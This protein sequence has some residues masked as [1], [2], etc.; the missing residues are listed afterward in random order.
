GRS[1]LVAQFLDLRARLTTREFRLELAA[2]FPGQ[3][4][5]IDERHSMKRPQ[6]R[7]SP[8]L[9][10]V[11]QSEHR[12]PRI[13]NDRERLETELRDDRAKI[14]DVGSP[15]DG[16]A[17]VRSGFASTTLIVKE[18]IVCL[19]PLQHLRQKVPMVRAWTT[20]K[21]EQTQRIHLTIFDSV[22]RRY[23]LIGELTL[24]RHGCCV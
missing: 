14:F 2:I 12:A 13:A 11:K 20:V 8:L 17:G 3:G 21:Q 6:L 15:G 7:V 22:T 24:S 18:E 1:E 23:S 16:D 19:S 5:W 10:C 4:R 9:D